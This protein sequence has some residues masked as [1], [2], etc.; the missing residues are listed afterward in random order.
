MVP[1]SRRDADVREVVLHRDLGDER[2]RAVA[3][4]HPDHLGR[5][6]CLVCERSQIVAGRDD[7]RLDPPAPGFAHEVEPLDL[8]SSRSGVHEQDRSTWPRS[9]RQSLRRFPRSRSAER[10]PAGGGKE[11]GGENEQDELVDRSQ[12]DQ[13][14]RG[15]DEYGSRSHRGKHWD[16]TTSGHRDPGGRPGDQK[17]PERYQERG[18]VPHDE[19]RER[20]D[21]DRCGGESHDRCNAPRALFHRCGR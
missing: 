9:T 10:A 13:R 1:R 3:A 18:D 17:R 16:R 21:H 19:Q 12:G 11:S 2:L 6:C 15:T 4:R 20:D 14:D 8:A 5:A 7:H